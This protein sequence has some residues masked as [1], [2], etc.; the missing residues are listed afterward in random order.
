MKFNV[1]FWQNI[2][3]IHQSSFLN[4]LSLKK[5]YNVILI[6]TEKIPSSRL[7]MG[8][9]EPTLNG[10]EVYKFNELGEKWK[11]FIDENK[12]QNAIHIFSGINAFENVHKVFS[13][14]VKRKCRVGIFTEPL[15][16]RGI[17]G[18]LRYFRGI[19]HRLLYENSIEFILGTGKYAVK[20]FSLWG[21]NSQKIFEW[22]YTTSLPENSLIGFVNQSEDKFRIMYAGS[23][24]K[25]KGVDLLIDALE[26]N[27]E[28]DFNAD[29]YC[30]SI[31]SNKPQLLTNCPE[32]I[33]FFEF[34]P[35]ENI[36]AKM[37]D[38]DLLV[39]PS[40]HDGWGAVVQESIMEGTRV[41]VS[42]KCGSST[43]VTGE[44]IGRVIH[45]LNSETL[46][47]EIRKFIS[48]GRITLEQRKIN[49][50]WAEE[51][52]S[53]VAMADYFEKILQFLDGNLSNKPK[54]PWN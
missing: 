40:R 8:W 6:T 41:L 12:S 27:N 18:K 38:Y 46:A 53:G 37:N 9:K 39:L 34:I 52:I 3:S 4:A 43:L 28:L 50:L 10:V 23:Y 14:A 51:K 26:K 48:E 49:R 54:V 45:R 36:R 44:Q 20:Q 32:K 13:Y 2:N 30:L 31:R 42:S 21:Y 11:Y 15:D 1:F 16:F 7:G 17:K 47:S 19:Y 5:D 29:L 35:N 25:R 33:H 24:I 22:G